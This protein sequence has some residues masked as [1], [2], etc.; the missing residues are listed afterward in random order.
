MLHKNPKERASLTKISESKWITPNESMKVDIKTC[1][2]PNTSKRG[3]SANLVFGNIDRLIQS[4]LMNQGATSKNLFRAS[5][6]GSEELKKQSSVKMAHV[7][8][9]T[10]GIQP[11]AES[12]GEH[13]VMEEN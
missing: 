11:V 9:G 4:K 7:R 12:M 13:S 6:G 2:S 10:S 3:S 8:H 1:D 5:T